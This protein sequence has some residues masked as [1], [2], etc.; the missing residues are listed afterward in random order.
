M[1]SNDFHDVGII[2]PRYTWCN[3]KEGNSKIWERLDRCILNS[4]ALKLLPTAATRHLAMV[5]SDHSLI[6]LKMNDKVRLNSKIIRFEDTWRLY[7]AARSI[8]YHSWREKDGGEEGLILQKKIN[9]TL[10]AL[11]FWSRSKCKDLNDL[12]VK[13]KM[14]I[15]ELQ[16][17]E[18]LGIGWTNQDLLLLRSKIHDLNVTLKRLS[19]WWN[20]RAK[21][22][23]IEEGDFNSKLFHNFASILENTTNSRNPKGSLRKHHIDFSSFGGGHQEI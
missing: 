2:E 23:W 12:K 14:E 20:Q 7:P 8:V 3:N 10:K 19:T 4:T 22:R 16:T 17:K 6:I 1:T 21:A 13:L 9:K 15:L 18:A 11:F 5:A